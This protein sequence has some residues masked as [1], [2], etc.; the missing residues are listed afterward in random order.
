MWTKMKDLLDFDTEKKMDYQHAAKAVNL[1]SNTLH[2]CQSESVWMDS[3]L[4]PSSSAI[5]FEQFKN[6]FTFDNRIYYGFSYNFTKEN[7]EEQVK[8]CKFLKTVGFTGLSP[9]KNILQATFA[10]KK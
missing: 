8:I 10:G 5:N 7:T 1:I 9:S 4:D 2:F 6:K 3:M